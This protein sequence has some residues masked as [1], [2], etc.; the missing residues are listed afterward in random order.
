M[1]D[2]IA[3]STKNVTL[4]REVRICPEIVA[5]EGYIVAGKIK[6][7]K[8]VY[9]TVENCDGRMVS[10]H[11]GDILIGVLGHRNALHG[12]SGFVPE[13]IS[14]GDT[15]NVL[16]LGGVIGKCNSVNPEVGTPFEFEVIGSVLVF[17]NFGSRVGVPAHIGMNAVRDG[18]HFR[19]LKIPPIIFVVGTC[20]NAGKTLAASQLIRSLAVKDMKVGACKLTGVSLLRDT[21]AMKDHGAS[22]ALSFNDAGIVTT[23][24]ETSAEGAKEILARLSDSDCEVIV[25]E[26]GDGILGEYGVQEILEDKEIMANAAATVLCANDPVGVWGGIKILKE[27]YGIRTDIVTGPATDNAVGIRF[28]ESSFDLKAINARSNGDKFGKTIFSIVT[29]EE[30]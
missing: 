2:K 20:M 19:E 22:V 24:K 26:L 12:Y 7:E 4:G 25:A 13:K 14:A 8:T 11:D 30:A 10:L 6:G 9:N 29:K 17:P 3:S 18:R 23:S 15:L 16:N 5:E 27:R 21:L 28:I 1:A